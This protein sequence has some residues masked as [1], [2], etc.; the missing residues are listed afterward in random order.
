MNCV[1]E[2]KLYSEVKKERFKKIAEQ[3]T[4]K[5]IKTLRLLGNCANKSNYDYTDEE[6][7]KIFVAIEKELKATK[8]KFLYI[9]NEEIFKL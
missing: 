2:N 3:R 6:V 8:N 1:N 9:E 4:N 5:L 7:K